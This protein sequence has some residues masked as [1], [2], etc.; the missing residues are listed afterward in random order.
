MNNTSVVIVEQLELSG[1]RATLLS[2]ECLAQIAETYDEL[3]TIYTTESH[4]SKTVPT[5][6]AT[7]NP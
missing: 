4:I 6:P 3:P 2:Y 7:I 1:F 5:V